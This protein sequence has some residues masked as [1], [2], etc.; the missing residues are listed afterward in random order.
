MIIGHSPELVDGN[1]SREPFMVLF[2]TVTLG[3][4][5][6]NGFFILSGFLITQS[7]LR[8]SNFLNYLA[9][10]SIR[11]YPGLIFASIISALV[12]GP[13]GGNPRYWSEFRVGRFIGGMLTLAMPNLPDTFVE[14]HYPI[15]NGPIWTIRY[16]FAC[17]LGLA[18][19][20]MLGFLR[21]RGWILGLVVGLLAFVVVQACGVTPALPSKWI[22][23][24]KGR[25]LPRLVSCFMVGS[26]FF[27]FRE[28]IRYTWYG[29][30]I[31]LV[32]LFVCLYHQPALSVLTPP[33]VGYLI[34]AVGFG[35]TI[36]LTGW[37][38]KVDV[39]YG[40]YLYAWPFQ[41]LII[42]NFRSI[43][44]SLL[45]AL[46]IPMAMVSGWLSWSLVEKAPL[47]WVH[48]RFAA[49]EQPRQ[50]ISIGA[51]SLKIAEI[52]GVRG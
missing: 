4:F 44:P 14:L 9:R 25:E 6:V 47:R 24:Y 32:T 29:M 42:W 50:H 40:V 17:Y 30:A 36:P 11:I 7:W 26:C 8:S 34:F 37:V 31:T 43:D 12:F 48:R 38:R 39:S 21:R 35:P 1:R 41:T 3:H 20:G 16:E 49:R 51:D 13:L 46:V 19:L 45:S 10:R 18:L 28:M 52:T 27:L 15:V 33:M 2:G 5:A 22:L 23:S